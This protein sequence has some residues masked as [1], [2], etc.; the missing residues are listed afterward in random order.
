[1]RSALPLPMLILAMCAAPLGGL[2]GCAS[3]SDREDQ[4]IR[5]EMA[6]MIANDAAVNAALRENINVDPEL[7]ASANDDAVRPPDAAR[8]SSVPMPVT[9]ASASALATLAEADARKAAGGAVQRAPAA[10]A[11]SSAQA[12]P[13]TLGGVAQASGK[14]GKGCDRQMTYGAAWANRMPAPF[15]I[16]PRGN[17]AEA[18]GV[19]NGPC[20]LVAI[21]FTTPVLADKVIDYYYTRARAAGYSAE[22]LLADKEHRLGGT[23]NA[24]P[25]YM[26]F[27]RP[28]ADGR[29]EVDIVANAS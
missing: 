17:L 15:A 23:R 13:L 3:P 19:A 26:V 22:H 14:L 21:S 10:Q 20:Q 16:Y 18:A 4:R 2:A 1:M 11:V 7:A 28:L 6:G 25:A 12:R 5:D 29:T 24:G 27:A 8:G 9:G